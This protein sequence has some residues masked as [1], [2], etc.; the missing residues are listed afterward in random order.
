MIEKL[1]TRKTILWE[2]GISIL[3]FAGLAALFA[4][5][6]LFEKFYDFS[7]A[8][9]DYE[10]DDVFAAL[11]A[12]PA[13]LLVFSVR[14][15]FDLKAEKALREQT[16]EAVQTLVS[17][18]PLTGLANRF[19]M[20][21]EI[22]ARLEVCET[23]QTRY[24]LCHIDLDRFKQINDRYG[25][26]TGDQ[27]LK[28]VASLLKTRNNDGAIL[29]RIASDE[30][31]L[32]K[33]FKRNSEVSDLGANLVRLLNSPFSH[34]GVSHSVS[35]S[36]G[37]ALTDDLIAA[38]SLSAE[39]LLTNAD[40]AM[41]A[42]KS[43]GG[44]RF[45]VYH[46]SMGEAF[47]ERTRLAAELKTACE[48]NEFEPFFQ[49][50]VDARTFEIVGA[51]ALVRWRHPE[52]GILAPGAFLA[53]AE[54]LGLVNTIDHYMLGKALGIRHK[55]KALGTFV[56][57]ISINV[58]ADRLKSPLFLHTIR[59]MSVEPDA[60]IFEISEAVTFENLDDMSRFNLE[61]L[62]DQGFEVEIDDF[63]SGRASILSLLE[64]KPKRLKIDRNLIA[65]IATSNSSRKLVKSIV[66]MAAALKIDVVGE[67][68]ET[69]EHA[70][71]LAG[72]GCSLLQG[73]YFAAPMSEAEF[74]KLLTQQQGAGVP[75]AEL[76]A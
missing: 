76:S 59:N 19:Q 66:D 28:Q 43:G 12:L 33:P 71:I 73:Y 16:Q 21:S 53:T 30:F 22:K 36:V 13:I 51:E 25:P 75:A 32:L 45:E 24:A 54:R 20:F 57:R 40:I 63:G 27:I 10:L 74:I 17:T 37:I 52:K 61:A 55:F 18:D 50:I 64:M 58:S 49:P 15:I 2:I 6:D 70:K 34:H 9:E 7:R 26:V 31:L 47:E 39:R 48:R 4:T 23:R 65:P 1:A 46:P 62:A 72:Q 41:F 5:V 42:A 44:N 35:A 60:L 8:H 14:R 68:V 69:L 38:G 29:A 67:G 56:P 3:A 11:L